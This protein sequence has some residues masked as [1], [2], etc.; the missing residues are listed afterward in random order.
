MS[1][2]A[3]RTLTPFFAQ[4]WF[5]RVRRTDPALLNRPFEVT[6]SA[7]NRPIEVALTNRSRAERSK[8]PRS[9]VSFIA[10][11]TRK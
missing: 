9:Q 5:E 6:P 2:P 4:G 1:S 10:H 8:S 7:F 11:G 3:K